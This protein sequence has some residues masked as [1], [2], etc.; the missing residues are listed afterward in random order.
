M[1]LMHIIDS[2]YNFQQ[3]QNILSYYLPRPLT[4]DAVYCMS[5]PA[6]YFNSLL[7]IDIYV[8]PCYIWWHRR[9]MLLFLTLS[10]YFSDLSLGTTLNMWHASVKMWRATLKEETSNHNTNSGIGNINPVSAV[11]AIWHHIIVSFNAL[12]TERVHWN[13]DIT[14][15][16]ASVRD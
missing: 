12:G 8:Y 2:C 5:L 16:N 1:I 4:L 15:W 11:V 3:C 7:G 10:F 6:D 13:L 14:G 9:D